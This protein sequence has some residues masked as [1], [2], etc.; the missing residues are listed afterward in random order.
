[1]VGVAV[2]VT[3]VWEQMPV[4]LPEAIET[5]GT[6]LVFTVMVSVLE[7]AVTGEAHGALEVITTD[8]K[9]PLAGV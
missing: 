6:R 7:V 9:S 3:A 8:I 2:K 5:D 1:M 4:P